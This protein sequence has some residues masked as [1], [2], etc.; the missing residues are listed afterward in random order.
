MFKQATD[1]VNAL[2]VKETWQIDHNGIHG[3]GTALVIPE[4]ISIITYYIFFYINLYIH[5]YIYFF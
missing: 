5:I 1:Q 3:G 2:P 4:N